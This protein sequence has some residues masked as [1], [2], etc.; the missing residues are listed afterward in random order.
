L[1]WAEVRA[2]AQEGVSQREIARRSGLN[3]RTVARMVA[4]EQPPRYARASPG[5]Q[6]DPL[7]GAIGRALRKTPDIK[8]P[9]LT[10]LLRDGDGYEGSV[11]LV[12]RRL[13]KLRASGEGISV[14]AGHRAGELVQFDW[15]EM[16]TRQRVLG[17]ER[18]IYA[19]IASLPFSGIQT[20]HFSLDLT[21]ESFLE[22]HV[23]VFDWLEGVPAECT[24]RNLWPVFAKRDR[25]EAIRW[26]AR[27]RRLRTHYAFRSTASV[28]PVAPA[29]DLLGDA[30]GHLKGDF[31]VARPFA[32]LGELDARYAVWRDHLARPPRDG[33]GRVIGTEMDRQERMALRALPKGRFDFSLQRTVKVPVGGYLRHGA[34]FYRAPL[35]LIDQN[36][37][38]HASREEVWMVRH[39]ER[40]ATYPRSYKPG[41]WLPARRA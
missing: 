34:A 5:S 17:V 11:D 14:R 29:S 24:Y 36:V 23:R 25:R 8:A 41:S 20:A 1:Q 3:R 26:N 30:I 33:Q 12:R 9:A 19:L 22:G 10:K 6:L 35:D 38:L 13:A 39:G 32:G 2:L 21:I 7:A 31:W 27:Y 4:T 40:V 16:P 28:A 37:D 15:A 18:S